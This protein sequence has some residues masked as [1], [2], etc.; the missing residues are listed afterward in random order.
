MAA[1]TV[2]VWDWQSSRERPSITTRLIR[3]PAVSPPPQTA[4]QLD[5]S[6]MAESLRPRGA[7]GQIY[8][9]FAC[10]SAQAI[11]L[12]LG[13]VPVKRPSSWMP[14]GLVTLTS[15]RRSPITSRPTK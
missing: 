8:R 6:F 12:S 9:F 15:V 4:Q 5:L 7:P 1:T 14:V 3:A 2:A 10:A 11:T 13:R